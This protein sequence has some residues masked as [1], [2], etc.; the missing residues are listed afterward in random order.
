MNTVEWKNTDI[1]HE[2]KMKKT[3][4][5]LLQAYRLRAGLTVVEL[6]K[7]AGTKYPNISA[8]ENDRRSIGLKMARK[9]ADVLKVDYK[10]FI[11]A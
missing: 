11:E 10:K 9:L 7:L 6:A 5:K 1:A 2:I 8:M 4:G 3:P